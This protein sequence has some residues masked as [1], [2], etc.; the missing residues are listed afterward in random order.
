MDNILD[1]KNINNAQHPSRQ[2]AILILE[3]IAGKMGKEDMFEGVL[4]YELEDMITYI[5]EGA[6][7]K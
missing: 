3:A 6:K 7:L 4:W 1:H 2:K 5:V